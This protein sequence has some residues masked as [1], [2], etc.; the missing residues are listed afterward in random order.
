MG[1]WADHPNAAMERTER[2]GDP[3]RP[4]YRLHG[5]LNECP[6]HVGKVRRAR[7]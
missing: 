4:Q 5:K 2:R 1:L 3:L 7:G 6:E